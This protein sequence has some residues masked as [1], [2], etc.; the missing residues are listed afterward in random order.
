VLALV[1]ED[2]PLLPLLWPP[3]HFRIELV[4]DDTTLTAFKAMNPTTVLA[5]GATRSA[6]PEICRYLEESGEFECLGSHPYIS[7]LADGPEIWSLYRRKDAGPVA[8]PPR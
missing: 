2:R 5:G 4:D 1:S 7:K 6:F 8:A 3:H